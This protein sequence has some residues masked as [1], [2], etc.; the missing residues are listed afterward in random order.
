LQLLLQVINVG[1]SLLDME[2]RSILF[3]LDVDFFKLY[4]MVIIDCVKLTRSRIFFDG[5][6][7]VL[8]PFHYLETFLF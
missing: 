1:I 5:K 7:I 4:Y 2:I 3:S 6:D 8:V